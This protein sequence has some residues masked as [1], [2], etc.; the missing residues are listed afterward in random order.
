MTTVH[1]I[2]RWQS[3]QHRFFSLIQ[4]HSVLFAVAS[5]HLSTIIDVAYQVCI[6]ITLS[7][8]S[9]SHKRYTILYVT[10]WVMFLLYECK[11]WTRN[12]TVHIIIACTCNLLMQI[13]YLRKTPNMCIHTSLGSYIFNICVIVFL[14]FPFK[15]DN[16]N[17]ACP[18][19]RYTS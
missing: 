14:L 5:D 15:D 12:K 2:A 16:T 19:E 18:V 8:M 6:G 4:R 13:H 10:L 17:K 7:I 3:Q 1:V 11:N 9:Y